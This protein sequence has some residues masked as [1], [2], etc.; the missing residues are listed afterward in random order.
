M[1]RDAVVRRMTDVGIVPVLRA[2]SADEAIAVAD[3]V[4]A[5]GIDVLEITMTVPGAVQVIAQV[6]RRYGER[7]LVGAGTV[8]DVKAA[9]ECLAAGACFIVSP[10]IDEPTIAL[11]RREDVAVLPG[12][13]TPTEVVSAWRAGADLVKVFPCGSV[14]GPRYIQA[15]KAPLPQIPLV[16]TGGVTAATAAAYF[17]AG[18]SAIGVGS[19][20]CDVSAIREKRPERITHAAR[21]YLEAVQAARASV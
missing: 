13:L 14:G 5:G 18:A 11:C 9:G 21:A 16:P 6:V 15:L 2:S 17:A 20:L 8:L 19:D 3:A 7:V 12:A 4:A 10:I 1:T